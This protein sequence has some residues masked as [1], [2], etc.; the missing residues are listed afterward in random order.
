ML[1]RSTRARPQQTNFIGD[2][3]NYCARLLAAKEADVLYA[4]EEFFQKARRAGCARIFKRTRLRM[5]H[6]SEPV[7]V[8]FLELA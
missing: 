1:E 8:R 5:K 4:S 3:I 7:P 2:G 6:V